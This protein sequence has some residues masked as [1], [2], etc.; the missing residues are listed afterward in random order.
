MR[1]LVSIQR[2]LRE[3]VAEGMDAS[4]AQI[5]AELD[6]QSNAYGDLLLLQGQ[7]ADI[8]SAATRG[9]IS[10]ENLQLAINKIREGLLNLINGLRESDLRDY[11]KI[12]PKQS[13][14]QQVPVKNDLPP[15]KPKEP[16]KQQKA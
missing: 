4:I 12:K 9:T 13:R 11:Q 3:S 15:T 1:E 14:T 10:E 7:L 2:K 5:K 8:R 16:A 6:D